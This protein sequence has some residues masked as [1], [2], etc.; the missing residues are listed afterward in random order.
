MKEIKAREGYYLTQAAEVS[1]RIFVTRVKGL[2]VNPNDW[3]E[4]T[5]EEKIAY[6][7]KND[8][9]TE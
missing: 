5:K 8:E 2:N 6:E 4:A 1:D 7:A 9:P 3:R